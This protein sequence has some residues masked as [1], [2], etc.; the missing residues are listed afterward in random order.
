MTL[1]LELFNKFVSDITIARQIQ[2]ERN[3]QKALEE[4]IQKEDIETLQRVLQPVLEETVASPIHKLHKG[5]I[6]NLKQI[7]GR[8]NRHGFFRR[9]QRTDTKVSFENI[10]EESNPIQI[11][12][13][14]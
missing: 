3:E 5:L 8:Q 14:T 2:R 11:L 6:K 1:S 12:F 10:F 4:E 13:L 7:E 9:T